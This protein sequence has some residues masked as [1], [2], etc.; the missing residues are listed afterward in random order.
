MLL[1]CV[2]QLLDTAKVPSSLILS[3][4]MMEAKRSSKM[5]VLKPVIYRH[6]PEECSLEIYL[7]RN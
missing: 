1:R 3:T 4:L 2:L 7:V 6:I 5:S